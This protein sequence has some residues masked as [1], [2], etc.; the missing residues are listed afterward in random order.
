[1]AP[2]AVGRPGQPHALI[3]AIDVGTTAVKAAIVDETGAIV[4]TG[5][6][7]QRTL[8][9]ER[10]G[11]EHE[12]AAT[13]RAVQAAVRRAL[14]TPDHARQV[15]A[16]SVTGPRGTFRVLGPDGQPRSRFLTWQDRRA[17][18]TAA[19]LSMRD[20]GRYRTISGTALEPSVV[21]PK[22]VWLR[23]EE[24]RLFEGPWALATPQGDVLARLGADGQVVDLTVAAHVGLLDVTRLSWSGTL[25]A[26]FDVPQRAMPRLVEPGAQV[27]RLDPRIAAAWRL[28]AG[29]PLVAAGSDGVC[30]ELGAGVTEP[31]QVYAYLGTA[32]AVA[33]PITAPRLPGDPA[34]KLLPGSVR[35][36]WRI[37]A[38]AGAGASVRDWFMA[39]H[40]LRDQARVERLIAESP[41]GAR[42]ALFLPTLA[43]ASAPVPDGRA[44]GVFAGLTLAVRTADLARAVHEGVALELRW[45]IAAMRDS[46]PMPTEIRL[47]G[48]GSRS[49]GWSRIIADALGVPV[50]RVTE[51]HPGLR[52]AACYGW[53]AV[54]R[55][56]SALEAARALDTGVDWFVPGRDCGALYDEAA[57]SYALVR[58]AF[59]EG[60]VDGRLFR[61]RPPAGLRSP[62]SPPP[63]RQR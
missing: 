36:R 12:P 10:G 27:G 6:A 44:R 26:E 46:I 32:A 49:D 59:H 21:L 4:S 38:L 63:G 7:A 17:A 37:V 5:S 8:G 57:E 60:G 45:M 55:F 18:D 11:R 20:D 39:T 24:P 40:G 16:I 35:E 42:G 9:D 53:S 3:L 14:S 30:S 29:I 41:P 50:A 62:E 19:T 31:G 48:G 33:G 1:M 2:R 56:G 15:R 52:G 23:D 51:P 25:L 43:G 58:R 54:G 34:L 47:T 13:W 22:L 61:Q 28:P